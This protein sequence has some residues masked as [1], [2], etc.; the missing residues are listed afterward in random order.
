VPPNFTLVCNT[1]TGSGRASSSFSTTQVVFHLRIRTEK[2]APANDEWRI[3]LTCKRARA[4]AN[5]LAA[6]SLGASGYL[7]VYASCAVVGNGGGRDPRGGAGIDRHEAVFRFNL[8]QTKDHEGFVGS[9]TTVRVLNHLRSRAMYTLLK[10]SSRTQPN[11]MVTL[12]QNGLTS[13]EYIDVSRRKWLDPG[14]FRGRCGLIDNFYQMRDTLLHEGHS[15]Y[16]NIGALIQR[17]RTQ[18]APLPHP[19]PPVCLL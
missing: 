1:S 4:S 18:C 2:Y 17:Q 10:K 16:H 3:V 8:A 14:M 12:S 13:D 9:K 11:A 19:K 7:Q 6:P 5:S 15:L